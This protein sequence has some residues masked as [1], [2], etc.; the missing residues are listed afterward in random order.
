[1]A[2]MKGLG[3]AAVLAC[4]CGA[5]PRG[6]AAYVVTAKDDTP[7]GRAALGAQLGAGDDTLGDGF[8]V[9]LDD[10]ARARVAAM[11]SVASV[12]P[13]PAAAKHG[14]LPAGGS[15]AVRI[16]LYADASASEVDA[17]AAW[18]TAHGGSVAARGG[19]WLDATLPAASAAGAAELAAVRWIEARAR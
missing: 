18:V 6:R 15:L 4:A 17:V 11:A 8:V 7:A 13:L 16:D 9:R 10:A 12:A 5:A 2:A 1:M 3:I 14:A 19:T